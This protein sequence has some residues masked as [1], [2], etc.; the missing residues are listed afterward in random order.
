MWYR[1]HGNVMEIK[2]KTDMENKK[3]Y[4]NL[5]QTKNL[6][7]QGKQCCCNSKTKKKVSKKIIVFRIF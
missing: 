4:G 7:N 3:R 1:K 5:I 6:Q 2:Y